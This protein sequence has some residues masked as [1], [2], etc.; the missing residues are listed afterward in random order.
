MSKSN[1]LNINEENFCTLK[2]NEQRKVLYDNLKHLTGLKTQLK[3]QWWWL[4][5]LTS[6]LVGAVIWISELISKK[7]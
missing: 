1:G 6:G 2:A 3:I 7:L 4:G 5:A